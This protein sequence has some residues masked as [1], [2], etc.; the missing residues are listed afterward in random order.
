[1]KSLEDK[2]GK[3]SIQQIDYKRQGSNK[4]KV[5]NKLIIRLRDKEVT[6]GKSRIHSVPYIFKLSFG[7]ISAI[8][9]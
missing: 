8:I 6:K 2:V 7:V 4:G 9:N 1:M 3:A 5:F